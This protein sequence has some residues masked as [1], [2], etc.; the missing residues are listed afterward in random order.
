MALAQF[1][2]SGGT[3][4]AQPVED[5]LEALVREH[6]RLVYRVA[7]SVAALLRPN[8]VRLCFCLHINHLPGL[9][10]LSLATTQDTHAEAIETA[11]P[12][13]LCGCGSS[14]G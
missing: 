9:P 8:L 1:L 4:M 3:A 10:H 2:V 11:H 7:F 14:P 12:C 5:E 13:A 6:A